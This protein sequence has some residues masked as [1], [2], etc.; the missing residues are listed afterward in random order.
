VKY[1]AATVV[2][3]VDDVDIEDFGCWCGSMC[4]GPHSPQMQTLFTEKLS[5][6]NVEFGTIFGVIYDRISNP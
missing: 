4:L 2:D 1:A 5:V 6:Y 3:V